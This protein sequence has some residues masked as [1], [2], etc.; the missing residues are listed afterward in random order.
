MAKNAFRS[1]VPIPRLAAAYSFEQVSL[2]D[3]PQE[4]WPQPGSDIAVT[5][6]TPELMQHFESCPVLHQP[7]YFLLNR[8][9]RAIAYFFIVLAG[10]QVRLADYGPAALDESTA[11]AIG[12]AAQLAAKE[13]YPGAVWIAAATSEP[14]VRSGLLQS[15]FRQF[16]EEEIRGLIVD[17]ALSSVREY[18]L[19]YLDCDALCL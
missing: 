18:R 5:A 16:Y 6:R 8:Q 19:T 11:E 2:T 12:V 13:Y 7:M 9:G 15:G 14:A 17:P 4:L 10:S 3:I 1:L